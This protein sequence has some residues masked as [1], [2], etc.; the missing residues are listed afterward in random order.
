MTRFRRQSP[1]KVNLVL[2]ILGRRPDGYHDL[3]TLFFHVPVFDELEFEPSAGAFEFQCDHAELPADGSNLVVRAA[4]RFFE[5]AG[6]GDPAVRIRLHKHLPLAAGLG[7]GSA[8]AAHVLAGLNEFFGGPLE[9]SA[10][11]EI[12]AGLGSDVNFFLQDRPALATG[13]GERIEPVAPFEALRSHWMFLFHPGFGIST[14][15]AYRELARFP[16]ALNGRPGRAAEVAAQ[17]AR[18]DFSS[19]GTGLYNSLEAPAFDK[20]PVLQ[21]YQEFLRSEGAWAALMSGSGSTTFAIFPNEA[22][23]RRAAAGFAERFGTAGWLQL[24]A[25]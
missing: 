19:A 10:L 15:W 3:E 8:N 25:L 13:R 20:Y 7:G 18:G 21:L 14:A 1:C 17:L 6:L 22:A 23:A 16:S 12:A 4:R 5:R 11:H 9:S 24:V 2:N